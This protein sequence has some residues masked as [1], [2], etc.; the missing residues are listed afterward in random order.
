[1]ESDLKIIYNGRETSAIRNTSAGEVE[2]IPEYPGYV[3]LEFWKGGELVAFT[4]PIFI[5]D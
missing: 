2:F 5:E 4:N 3:Y 1:M